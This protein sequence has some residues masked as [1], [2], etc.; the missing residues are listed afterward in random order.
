MNEAAQ[1]VI[2]D[3]ED[4]NF[5]AVIPGKMNVENNKWFYIFNCSNPEEVAARGEKPVMSEELA[6]SYTISRKYLEWQ[7][8]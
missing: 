4:I 1:Y 8:V 2:L 6:L 3:E 5:W 7:S